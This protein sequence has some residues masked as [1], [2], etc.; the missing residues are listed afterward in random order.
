MIHKQLDKHLQNMLRK[1]PACFT[2]AICFAKPSGKTTLKVDINKAKTQPELWQRM[3]AKATSF[4]PEAKA[5]FANVT[6]A[7]RCWRT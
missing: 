6:T 7:G 5:W 3:K 1:W 2:G 4:I